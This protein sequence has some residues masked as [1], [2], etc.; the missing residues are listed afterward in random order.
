MD[1]ADGD[2]TGRQ[3]DEVALVFVGGHVDV[4][5]PAVIEHQTTP[6]EVIQVLAAVAAEMCPGMAD[7]VV[8]DRMAGSWGAFPESMSRGEQSDEQIAVAVDA[9][10]SGWPSVWPRGGDQNLAVCVC[11]GRVE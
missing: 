10:R 7:R 6:E 9:G 2:P 5:Q 3:E 8:A 11:T 1:A 4:G